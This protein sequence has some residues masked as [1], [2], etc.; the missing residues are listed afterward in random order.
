MFARARAVSRVTLVSALLVASCSPAG[1]RRIAYGHAD[2]DYCRMTVSD[3]RFGSELV[4]QHGKVKTFDSIE[5]LASY[6][7]QADSVGTVAA[8][9][10]TDFTHPGTLLPANEAT[11][12]RATSLHSPMGRGLVAVGPGADVATLARAI[13]ASAELTWAEVL[14]LVR[15]EQVHA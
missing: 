8:A 7:A 3:E 13:G 15:R 10:V 2:C 11:Y 1:P 12:L 14:T 9:Y 5:C 6:V 4:L